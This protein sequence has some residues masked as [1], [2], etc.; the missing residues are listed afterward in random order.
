MASKNFP[1]ERLT[2]DLRNL[3]FRAHQ[4]WGY[5]QAGISALITEDQTALIGSPGPYTWRGTVFAYSVE[6]D[7]LFRDKKIYHIP[8]VRSHSPVDKYAY[9]GMSVASGNFLP[10]SRTCGHRLSY[11][12]GAPRSE[13]VGAVFFFH[14]C[15]GE[16]EMR[17]DQRLR[18][19]KFASR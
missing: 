12:V 6:D 18:G 19:E 13:D 14:K 9:L 10:T 17:V 11:A 4:E 8:V 1:A 2:Q 5:C 16:T 3:S 15:D 7:F